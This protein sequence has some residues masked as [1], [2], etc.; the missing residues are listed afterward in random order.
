MHAFVPPGTPY[1]AC[2]ATATR[3][4]YEEVVTALEMSGCVKVSMSHDR[5]NIFYSVKFRT[6]IEKDFSDLLS[7]LRMTSSK[8]L[9]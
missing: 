6:E 5:Q 7:S 8:L 1:M 4:V 3:D 2:T 9:G